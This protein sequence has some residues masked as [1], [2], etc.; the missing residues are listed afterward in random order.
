MRRLMVKLDHSSLWIGTTGNIFSKLLVDVHNLA[1]Q[2]L[3]QFY[4]G[5]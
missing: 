4:K 5:H 1:F 3:T 2:Q